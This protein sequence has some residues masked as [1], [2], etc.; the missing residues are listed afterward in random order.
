MFLPGTR[1]TFGVLNLSLSSRTPRS[2]QS[3]GHENTIQ[4]FRDGRIVEGD[5]ETVKCVVRGAVSKCRE[6]G[7]ATNRL[8]DLPRPQEAV[9]SSASATA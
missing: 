8:L 5:A 4:R 1:S 2:R 9:V 6:E 3:I 7:M